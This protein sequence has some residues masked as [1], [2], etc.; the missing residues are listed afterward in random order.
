MLRSLTSR[1][2]KKPPD[3]SVQFALSSE[4]EGA[5]IELSIDQERFLLTLFLAALPISPFNRTLNA[6]IS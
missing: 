3:I 5:Q 6:P 1:R 4:L 2:K